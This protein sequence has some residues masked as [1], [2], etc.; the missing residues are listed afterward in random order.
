[1]RGVGV[2]AL[3]SL[4]GGCATMP[5][6]TDDEPPRIIREVE[7]EGNEALSDG[8]I[9]GGLANHPPQGLIFR[10][11]AAL[12]SL[13]LELDRR[14][15]ES[16]YHA[17]G[18]FEAAVTD[19]T[20]EPATPAPDVNL[21]FQVREG[22]PSAI[23]GF[24]V[25][26]VPEDARFER[27]DLEDLVG[28]RVGEPLDYDRYQTAMLRMR[29][30]LVRRGY[31]HAEVEGRV[32][33][34][35]ED[36][37]VVVRFDVDPGPVVYFGKVSVITDALP[38]SAVLARVA[39]K[40]GARFDPNLLELTEGRIYELPVVG[41]VRFEQ[42]AEG[43]PAVLDTVIHVGRA[44]PNELRIGA[45]AAAIGG[46]REAAYELRARIGYS[47]RG[48]LEPLTTLRLEARP[49]YGF[50]ATQPGFNIEARAELEKDD[51]L[52]PRL[53]ISNQV[54]YTV[55]RF[56]AFTTQGPAARVAL[57]RSFLLDR[58][59]VS[60]AL[61]FSHLDFTR[62]SAAIPVTDYEELGF[63]PC[64][65]PCTPDGDLEPL[66]LFYLEPAIN[67][68]GRNDPLNTRRGVFMRLRFE[69]GST[70]GRISAPYL[71]A[72][73]EIR[74]YIPAG[75]RVV[76]AARAMV[77]STLLNLRPL[78]IT[79]R[80]FSGGAESHRGFLRRRLS[81]GYFETAANAE[82]DVGQFIPVGGEA[83]VETSV[84]ARINLFRLFGNWFGTVLFVDAGDV[85]L[86][87]LAE[88]DLLNLH[89]ATGAGLRYHT[90]VGPI[91]VDLGYRLNRVPPAEQGFFDRI[92]FHFS[93]GEAF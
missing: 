85:G 69:L 81:P 92:A 55:A 75:P 42:P 22:R 3:A 18:Y 68:D 33:V 4:G 84:E 10:T 30:Y 24:E 72:N 86:R 27:E 80:F 77:G 60:S 8:A 44:T 45:G 49:G 28:L 78:P 5:A 14:R 36:Q 32:E 13:S 26:G 83:L 52:T 12:D 20:V 41:W 50:F 70:M 79:Q 89:V 9:T 34:R 90:P 7:V 56:L 38:E 54:L 51:F 88:I 15:I 31:A 17:R 2:I 65:G 74:G 21:R 43:R 66:R 63:P 71:R 61:Q 64:E 82:A 35:R 73:P 93:L 58:L 29:G 62:I 53:Q 19:V 6:G 40:E 48:F 16:L 1:M 47:R 59:A 87:S 11:Y 91:R 57:G 46:Q 25:T 67:Y 39:W 23:L 76:L 37:T